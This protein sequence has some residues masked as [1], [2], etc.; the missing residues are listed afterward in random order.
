MTVGR[1]RQLRKLEIGGEKL[2][3]DAIIGPSALKEALEE[4]SKVRFEQTLLAEYPQYTGP[5]EKLRGEKTLQSPKSLAAVWK[6]PFEVALQTATELVEVCFFEQRGTK[7]APEFW[8]PFLY[9]DALG[10]IQGTAG[11]DGDN[12]SD[13]ELPLSYSSP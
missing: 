2:S 11:L 1:D 7:D 4:V 12:S 13:D 3:G 5:L 10:M 6:V 9:R 8:V